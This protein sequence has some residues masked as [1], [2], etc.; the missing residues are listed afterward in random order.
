MR[1]K[2]LASAFLFGLC[3]L[4]AS[5][6]AAQSL[7]ENFGCR[8]QPAAIN[9][10]GK[11]FFDDQGEACVFGG[12]GRLRRSPPKRSGPTLSWSLGALPPD[13]AAKVTP[14]S[15]GAIVRLGLMANADTKRNALHEWNQ[16]IARAFEDVRP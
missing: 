4:A 5:P 8:E 7:S 1:A 13:I 10:D 14:L 15:S 3:A 11:H 2:P 9:D 6:A 16:E 12:S